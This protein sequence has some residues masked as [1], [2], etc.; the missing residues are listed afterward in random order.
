[1]NLADILTEHSRNRPMHPVIE[2]GDRI[3]T[4]S[5]FASLAGIAAQNMINAGLRRG[6]I[7]VISP[8]V[9]FTNYLVIFYALARIGAVSFP[10]SSKPGSVQQLKLYQDFAVKAIVTENAPVLIGDIHNLKAEE[11]CT[12]VPVDRASN[13]SEK[14]TTSFDPDNA[15]TISSSSGT[16]GQTK[17]IVLTHR[18]MHEWIAERAQH[19]G[20]NDSERYLSIFNISFSAARMLCM[21]IIHLGATIVTPVINPEN[22]IIRNITDRKI[23][24]TSMVPAQVR[25]LLQD[26][27]RGKP[28]VPQLE[29]HIGAASLSAQD[30]LYIRDQ[31][32]PKLIEGYATNEIGMLAYAGVKEQDEYPESVGRLI[33]GVEAEVVDDQDRP[34]PYGEVGH[35]RFRVPFMPGGYVH[36]NDLNR[37]MFRNGWF[38]PGDLASINEQGYIYLK[39][40]SDDVINNEGVKFYP[41]EVE[42]IL[43][44]HPA[45]KEASVVGW[46]H[47]SQGEIA[48]ACVV[49]DR[50]ETQQ[51]LQTF[52]R[53]RLAGFKVPRAIITVKALP[54]NHAGK[55]QKS[56]VKEILKQQFSSLQNRWGRPSPEHDPFL[57]AGFSTR[58]DDIFISTA[59]KSGTTWMQNILHQLRSG[60]DADFSSINHI[61]PWLETRVENK[62]WRDR[63]AEF[64][65]LAGPRIFKTH[66]T[67]D[68]TPG[69]GSARVIFVTRDPRDCCVSYY[70]HLMNMTKEAKKRYRV[71]THSSFNSFFEWWM[72]RGKWFRN[73]RSYW[74][75]AE[76]SNVLWLRYQD[77]KEDLEA[78]IDKIITFLHWDIPP[79]KRKN[80]I[81]NCTFDWM[82]SNAE[83]FVPRGQSNRPEYNIPGFIRKGIVGDHRTL[84]SSS[85]TDSILERVRNTLDIEC[86]KFLGLENE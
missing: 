36:D 44:E 75:H 18:Q 17:Y 2:T 81:A 40:R 47:P 1:M 25:K 55:V 74:N 39:G 68:Q 62:T 15:F 13:A 64:E 49:L 27:H 26:D 8:T 86:I 70:H 65:M 54:R 67:W 66:C 82:K 12:F 63:I 43:L 16:T 56:E 77:L 31:I 33:K 85:Q 37:K 78:E 83:K 69:A 9:S 4:Y 53:Q 22:G 14:T 61:V 29:L 48:V 76:D 38:Y 58:S 7:V 73:V 50:N 72:V 57:L 59:P 51:S 35:I 21:R 84:M 52:C 45:V 11:I 10:D 23:S 19:F 3:V 5:E 41:L 28:L 6:D 20:N 34:M 32:T 80:I 60:G 79:S 24:I 71:T 42:N 30:R 46:P